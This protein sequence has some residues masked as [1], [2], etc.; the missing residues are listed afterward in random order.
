[1]K[2]MLRPRRLVTAAL[3]V[4]LTLAFAACSNQ[5]LPNTTFDPHTEFGRDI[6]DLWDKLLFWG[7]IVFVFVEAALIFVVV[8]YRRRAGRPEPRHVHGNTTLEILWTRSEER[9][10]GIEGRYR[11]SR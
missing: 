9:R 7:T 8:R 6:D 4:V 1:M 5:E 3:T 10:V 11:C 2:A